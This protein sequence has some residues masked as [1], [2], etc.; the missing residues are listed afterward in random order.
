MSRRIDV[1]GMAS[2]VSMNVAQTPELLSHKRLTMPFRKR[3]CWQLGIPLALAI[4]GAMT[5]FENCAFAQIV[6][7]ATLGNENSQVTPNVNVRGLPADL[8][9]GG[10][11]RGANLFHSFEQFNVGN[12]QRVY[13]ANPAGIENILSRVTGN[14]LSNVLGTLGVDGGA[15]LFLLNPNGIIFGPNV[16][17]D[18]AGSFV[19]ST[20][21]RVVFNNGYQ[22]SAKNPDTPPLL[23]VNVPLGVQYGTNQ[24]RTTISNFGSLVVGQNLTLSAGNLDLQG[25]LQAGGDLTLFA[26]DTVKV[27]DAI[28]SPFIA[29][30]ARN[31]TIQG[32]QSVDILALNH[33]QSK[34]QSGGNL[35]LASDGN[36]SGD[37]HFFS[38]GSLS[39]LTLA[40]TPGNFV[41]WFDPIIQANGD[42][43]F[44]NYTGVALKV[45]ATGS[46]QGGNIRIT[47]AECA[48]GSPGC[49]GGI[50]ATDPD[51]A[52]LTGSPSVIL[53]AGLPSVNTPN[54]P[55]N[56][57]GTGFTATLGLPLGITV[58]DI[59]TSVRN[60][61]NGGNIILSAAKG[62]ITTGNLDSSSSSSFG[63][64]GNGGAIGL[65]AANDI[66]ITGDLDSSSSSLPSNESN[67][68]TITLQATHNIKITGN[69][70]TSSSFKGRGGNGGAISLEAANNIKI[71]GNLNSST[72]T[73]GSGGT[74]RLSAANDINITGDLDS[75]SP[76]NGTANSGQGGAITL[77][78]ANGSI[79][80]GNLSSYSYG[81]SGASQGGAITLF[82]ANGSITTGNLSSYSSSSFGKADQGGAISLTA[83]N[84]SITTGNSDSSSSSSS[85]GNAGNGGAISL[86]AAN[87]SITTG[88]SDSSS[89]VGIGNAGR[90]G[91][92]S[93]TAANGSITTGNLD[94]SSS[95]GVGNAGNG[96]AISLTAANDINTTGDLYSFSSAG[97]GNAGNGG[98]I[99]LTAANNINT[100]GDFLYSFS[101]AGDGNAGNGGAISLT[102]ANDINTTGD[103]YSF[104]SSR[105]GTAGNGGAISLIASGGD[106]SGQGNLSTVLGS[107]SISFQGTAGNGGNVALEAKNNVSNL[108][109]LT[110]S[111]SSQS[112]TVQV[113]GL[114]DLLL[115]NTN[116]L[117]SRQVTI[118]NPFRRD[119]FITLNV[120]GAGQSGDATVISSGNLT[121]SNSSIQSDTKGSDP[122]GNVTI[123]SLGLISFINSQIISNTSSTG[124]AGSI[125]LKAPEVQLDSSSSVSAQTSSNGRA[126]NL[127]LQPYNNG[128]TLTVNLQDGA[129]IS[130]ST[131]GA[132]KG[133]SVTVTAPKSVTISGNGI[134]SATADASSTGQAG[135]V[136]LSTP[137]LTITN[138]ARVSASTNSLNASA[139]GG[140]LTIQAEQLNLT[141]KSTIDAGTTGAAAGGNLRIQP[142]G[143]R[144]TLSVNFQDGSIA[145]ASSSGGGKG[146]TLT[147]TAP[148]SITVS[149]NGSFISAETSGA[150][151]GGDL[152]LNTGN[153]TVK[154]GAKVTVSSTGT[155]N[156]GNLNVN[157]NFILLDNGQLIA[158]TASG[159]GGNVN[160]NVK[161][162]LLMRHNSLIS[163]QAGNNGN[164][165]N[166]TINNS[167]FTVAVPRED[168]DIVADADRG[169]GGNI[170]ITTQGIFGLKFRPQRTPVSDITASSKF[171]LSGTVTINQLNLDPSR[172]LAQL[173]TNVVD[174]S[175]QIENR[176]TP[177]AAK[178]R[179]SFTITGRG[180]LP[181]NPSEP[182]SNDAV[183]TDLRLI[184][185]TT[186]TRSSS[187]D[188]KVIT[189]SQTVPLVEAQGWSLNEQGQVVLT[190][191][192]P[193][194]TPQQA[195][196]ASPECN[197]VKEKVQR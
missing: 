143:E 9:E 188:T 152:N 132:G 186:K 79:T 29:T 197:P 150:G 86:T 75:S 173:P 159:E 19:A 153:L 105:N 118:P 42:V 80:T 106:I 112:G 46:I 70:S 100:T 194:A 82:S 27:R 184:P 6:S 191:E 190:A 126:G 157:A 136:L 18:I 141:G 2:A 66:N 119:E 168:S 170:N 117:T 140:N 1:I 192:A 34:I 125:T 179:G 78:S 87:G 165:G 5:A 127:T 142:L 72:S 135:D 30:S 111:S 195:W 11:I 146:G 121:F 12:G 54:L 24:S 16:K 98:A 7:D 36:I 155:G 91:T 101:S 113:T 51:F 124:Q 109:I 90:G 167:G 148:E 81:V 187:Q 76:S 23:T 182:L 41:S 151:T 92:I 39:M 67:G 60:G 175:Q 189:H 55:Q 171:G 88:N 130:A 107:F 89:S 17:L 95:V 38:G 162:L 145:S 59:N 185:Q 15:N 169:N 174:V 32:N 33:P 74:I 102:A 180:G 25:Q 178:E 93:L 64:A 96:G 13:F 40:D 161:D 71:T 163:A 123:S 176:C 196:L 147:V 3:C 20:A 49:A 129:Q 50:P 172:G 177:E 68:G 137:Q 48:A 181:D 120:G 31:M 122:A 21:D 35:S 53:R 84:G 131:S 57:G 97:D 63:N 61:G 56:A 73:G 58:G 156:A 134:L 183:W 37:A 28:A 164:G 193:N 160:L 108:E 43:L 44:G 14:N 166:I 77:F 26:Q 114:G 94:S 85:D 144:P 138:E 158:E 116:I 115:T 110:L 154:D 83:S 133:G 99:S 69:L 22:F 139:T 4:T 104:S 8:I 47:G 65:T 45:E 10:A 103:L 62:S 149:G 52:T 128:Q